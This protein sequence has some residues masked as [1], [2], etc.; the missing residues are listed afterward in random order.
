MNSTKLQIGDV[1]SFKTHWQK[2]SLRSPDNMLSGESSSVLSGDLAV[3]VLLEKKG[4]K[5]P[6][7][8]FPG[9]GWAWAYPFDVEKVA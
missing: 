1:V 8:R 5:R 6:L 3:V 2:H 9:G 7:L 4:D